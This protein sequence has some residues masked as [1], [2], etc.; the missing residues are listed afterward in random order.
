MTDNLNVLRNAL[1][2]MGVQ[3]PYLWRALG[4]IWDAARRWTVVWLA[5]LVLQG[6]LPVAVVYLTRLLVDSLV[7][8]MGLGAE[9]ERLQSVLVLVGLMAGILILKEVL[10]SAAAYIRT[11]QAERVRDYM[12][13]LIHRKTMEVDLSF[14]D[15]AE[16][17]NQLHRARSGASYRTLGLLESLGVLLQNGITLVSMLVVL[18]P[19]GAWLPVALL[20]STL[21]ALYV[22]LQHRLQLHHWTIRTTEDERRAMYYDWLLT[23]RESAAEVRI[24]QLSNYLRQLYQTLRKRLRQE[25]IQLAKSQ[26]LA[27][28]AAGG[29]ALLVTGVAMGWMV[30]RV[31]EGQVSLGDLALFYQAFNQGQSLMRAF[32]ENFG[33][34]YSNTFFLGDMFDFLA[35][36]PRVVDP[37][38][39]LPLP[40]RISQGI[41]LEG[42]HFTYPD[43]HRPTLQDFNLCVEAG[44]IAAIVGVNGAGK[45]TLIKLLCRFYDPQAGRITIDG[46]D[47]RQFSADD[48][49]HS[50]TVLFQEPVHYSATVRQNILLG[51]IHANR[52]DA[53]VIAAAEAAGADDPISRLAQGYDTFLGKNF[54]GGADL[55]VG[56]WQRIALGRAFLRQAAL[57][58]L[59]EP[60]SAMDPW[61]ES[62]WLARFRKLAMGRTA[63]L[64]THR[65]T[66]AAFADMIYVMDQGKIVEAGNHQQLLKAGGRYAAS[67]REQMQ[68]WMDASSPPFGADLSA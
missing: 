42:I 60:T 59:D 20:A 21:P 64:I 16:Y 45:S 58:I 54:K 62:D 22:V 2:K 41:C 1:H 32:L 18:L 56:E 49:R 28:V 9:W 24:F 68:R 11:A 23:M 37:P 67:W 39:P 46:I 61:A 19:Y 6:L 65:F 26:G 48:L 31:L 5:L 50:I 27:E 15:S 30:W 51:D 47:L 34:I 36:K 29:S 35:L 7:D 12:S 44:Q 25:R 53:E 4:L 13:D 55:S 63:I 8:V 17:Y 57:I 3:L 14:Y 43:S 66:T 52:S 38:D 40:S 33:E 10:R